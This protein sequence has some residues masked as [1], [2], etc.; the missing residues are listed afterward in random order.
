MA[1]PITGLVGAA[2]GGL[3]AAMEH[4]RT[5]RELHLDRL[6]AD[7]RYREQQRAYNNDVRVE[8]TFEN[9]ARHRGI[10][11][12]IFGPRTITLY[13]V[14]DYVTDR[15]GNRYINQWGRNPQGFSAERLVRGWYAHGDFP[16]WDT[17]ENPR[18]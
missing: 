16:H 13:M 7:A 18:L 17:D 1:D 9:P 12:W 4:T 2:V 14:A 8:A 5:E 3:K 15:R 6:T 11:E 10:L